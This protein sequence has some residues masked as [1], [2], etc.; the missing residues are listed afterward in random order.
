MR[1]QLQ[2]GRGTCRTCAGLTLHVCVSLP[3][4]DPSSPQPGSVAT[5]PSRGSRVCPS[6]FSTA[7]RKPKASIW[8]GGPASVPGGGGPARPQPQ[9][10]G[11]GSDPPPL[12]AGSLLLSVCS[13]SGAERGPLSQ[14]PS[15]PHPPSSPAQKQPHAPPQPTAHKSLSP[16]D[17]ACPFHVPAAGWGLWGTSPSP[18][19]DS[20]LSDGSSSMA[21]VR[22]A[23]PPT[24]GGEGALQGGK[25]SF[26]T[27]LES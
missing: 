4:A 22:P 14:T 25:D 2:A 13:R 26:A 15:S 17:L 23:G 21:V 5:T 6:H 24:K 8:G 27:F 9:P 20:C 7:L 16:R 10:P 1:E 19:V 11:P 18:A 3:K 12:L